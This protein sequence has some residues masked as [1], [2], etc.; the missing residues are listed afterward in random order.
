MTSKSKNLIEHFNKLRTNFLEKV[1]T[2]YEIE[3]IHTL[4]GVQ[5]G[6]DRSHCYP[7]MTMDNGAKRCKHVEFNGLSNKYQVT[8]LFCGTFMRNFLLVQLVYQGREKKERI[9]T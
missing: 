8:A 9:I 4:P 7:F 2:T 3:D 1:A 6:S 5:F